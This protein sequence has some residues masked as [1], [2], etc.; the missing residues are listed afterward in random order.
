MN[1][2]AHQ[3]Y[4]L[5]HFLLRGCLLGCLLVGSRGA[6]AQ[7]QVTNKGR[8]ITINRD[9][10]LYING[11]YVNDATDVSQGQIINDGEMHI[12]GDIINRTR[13]YVF[14]KLNAATGTGIRLPEKFR[15]RVIFRGTGDQYIRG[16]S[17]VYF[18]DINL[19]KLA[20]TLTLEQN[21][22][23]FN[24]FQFGAGNLFLNNH[25]VE[26]DQNAA[27][28]GESDRS[29]VFGP[30]GFVKVR[31]FLDH[32]AV[33]TL[34]GLGL[35]LGAAE[36]LGYTTI[37]RGHAAYAAGNGSLLRYFRILPAEAGMATTLKQRYLNAERQPGMNEADF[38][39]YHSITDGVIWKN[40]GGVA[41]TAANTVAATDV[42]LPGP[43]APADSAIV[44]VSENTCTNPP[45]VNAGPPV[46][47]LC[48]GQ[49]HRLDAGIPGLFYR[50]SAAAP[51]QTLPV[52]TAQTLTVA[53][54]GTYTVRVTDAQ[55]CTTEAAM[56][57]VVQPR[58]VAG[59]TAT[60]VCHAS[61]TVFTNA[62]TITSGTLS[63][64][65]RFGDG[66]T[67]TLPNP[68]KTYAAPGTYEVFLKV[69][70]AYGCAD[71]VTRTVTVHPNPQPGFTAA[72]SCA[73]EA[74]TFTNTSAIDTAFDFPAGITTYA[75]NFGDGTT[76]S[77]TTATHPVQVYTDP[78]TYTVTLTTTSNA[79]CGR[80][81]TYTLTVHPQPLA[82]FTL[83]GA[84]AGRPAAF[85]NASTVPGGVATFAWDFGDGLTA[86]DEHPVHTFAQPGTYPVTLTVTTAAGCAAAFTREVTVHPLPGVD[87]TFT[88][89]CAGSPVAFT[90]QAALA[91]ET[92]AYAWYFGDGTTSDLPYPDKT[93]GTPGSY[94]VRLT[95]TSGSGCPVSVT[96]TVSIAP[97][98]LSRFSFNN[99][100]AGNAVYFVNTSTP[101][102]GVTYAWSLGDD[103]TSTE[104]HPVKVY[105]EPGTYQVSLTTTT[106]QGC[107]HTDTRTVTIYAKPTVDFGGTIATCGSSLVLD[108]G[109]PGST[110]R[111]SDGATTQTITVTQNGTYSVT[112]TSPQGCSAGSSVLVKLNS[113]VAPQLGPDR[114]VCGATR[115]DAGYPGAT[116]R[117][118]DGSTDR[119]LDVTATGSYSVQV[120][121]ANGCTGTASVRIT[122]NPVPVVGLG[123]DL[124]VCAGT[125]VLLNAGNPGASFQWSTGATGQTLAVT[126]A[127][128]YW[129]RVTDAL[130]GCPAF[131]TVRVQFLPRP[132]V[133]L[134]ADATV[135]STTWLDAGNP[136][137]TYQWSDGS[138]E[139]VLAVSRSGTYWVAVRTAAG[140]ETTGTVNITVQPP[141][142]VDLGPDQTVCSG[143]EVLLDA[144]NP[145]STYQWGDGSRGQTLRVASSGIYRVEVARPDGCKGFDEVRVTVQPRPVV[146]LGPDQAG[147]DGQVAVLNAGNPG[148]TYAWH[149][150]KGP[151]GNGQTLRV[152]EA[153]RYWVQVTSSAG[154][155][156]ADT[157]LV[158]PTG[159]SL[160]AVFLAASL[161]DVGETVQFVQLCYPTPTTFHWNF[162]DGVTSNRPDPAH[163]YYLPGTYQ[164][165]LA[166]GNGTCS[167]TLV[168]PITVRPLRRTEPVTVVTDPAKTE[169]VRVH[170]Y[171]NPNDGKFTL[172]VDLNQEGDLQLQV[173]DLRGVLHRTAT[174]R[175]NRYTAALDV[176]GLPPGMYLVRIAA[177]RR[178]HVKKFIKLQ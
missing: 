51:A 73:D 76:L 69:T 57:V 158:N 72:G 171:P 60:Q 38:A 165:S 18:F 96:K 156:A 111:W 2:Y 107:T 77:T 122:V 160:T 119:F 151:L 91:G 11:S 94:S 130:V 120:T 71:S 127:G 159:K 101:S 47:Y 129:V 59:F 27:L 41:D 173:V 118:S 152:T 121:D 48:E 137:S 61:P 175:T 36:K 177:G 95:V 86:T 162:G 33:D 12:T 64:A 44:T 7:V 102:A 63:Y 92:L 113:Q 6:L 143:T 26:L 105:R 140:C 148:A 32:P 25:T 75:W 56:Q 178:V 131:D 31:R 104:R 134:G 90:G 110:Y 85:A 24:R 16:D 35:H 132:V 146:D 164:V 58:P 9:T 166:A 68:A 13:N 81:F 50:W 82:A 3:L 108:A 19:N 66:T 114:T 1:F 125:P 169:I 103:S 163:V 52:D 67:S 34:N 54:A 98:P 80:T 40:K 135:C 106:A 70:S 170:L 139:R 112:V 53:T 123:P 145:G 65:W 28:A 126:A 79:G 78:G 30:D 84:C 161:V 37:L 89:A 17:A 93:Y 124:T 117:W 83:P 144:G 10:K 15:G 168:K 128:T 172:E 20:G 154:C 8:Q 115:L 46:V 39:A 147:C 149:S 142:Q 62:S 167:D 4:S 174:A 21:V 138:V 109:H 97:S 87:F 5:V 99:A 153:G 42:A 155:V 49:T 150:E 14:T 141:V 157:V 116:Y 136:G 100:C 176:S 45:L 133:N 23:V 43:E 29:R 88:A 55:G 74:I 22:G